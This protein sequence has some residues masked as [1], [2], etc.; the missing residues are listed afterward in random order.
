MQLSSGPAATVEMI[1]H[2]GEMTP[3]PD[4]RGYY[5]WVKHH[6][7]AFRFTGVRDLE[8]QRFDIPNTLIEMTFSSPS[9]FKSSGRFTVHPISVMG[10]DCFAKFSAEAG[11]V[12]SVKPC[13]KE[14]NPV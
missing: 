8:F 4:E 9:D 14:G 7:I 5:A 13:D 2:T 12:L 3:T 6:L 11:E 1:I 10:G